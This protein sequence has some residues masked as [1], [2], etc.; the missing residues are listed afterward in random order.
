M[1]LI[2]KLLYFML[3]AYIANMAP[4]LGK[5]ILKQLAVPIDRG[6]TW[7][8]KPILGK[9]KTWRGVFL[10]VAAGAVVFFIQQYL[11]RFDSMKAVSLIDY[12][13]AALWIGVLLGFGA[14]AGDSVE[15]FFKRRRGIK[16][17]KP[18]IPFDQTDFTIGA[19]A[20]CSIVYFP[21]WA[22]AAI[23]VAV[24]AFGHVLINHIGYYLKL[25]DVKW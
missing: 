7:K 24:S 5:N 16:S 1:L 25:R 9:N 15:S 11:Y 10:A 4:P 20:L 3:P 2:I 14:I 8:G 17:G 19:L 6:K 23:I 18:W 12:S 21:G 13:S 22:N